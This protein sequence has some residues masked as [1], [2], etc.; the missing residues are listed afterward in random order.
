MSTRTTFRP[1]SVI[2]NGDMS[3]TS[4]TSDVTV[5]QSLTRLSY[6]AKWTGTTPIGTIA[7]QVSNDYSLNADGTVNNAGTWNTLTV[8][9]N[10]TLVTS[11]PVTGNTG[12]GFIDVEATAAYAARLVYTKTSGTGTLNV[13]INAKVS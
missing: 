11:V 2:T 1:K 3:A 10:G 4:I 6:A 9:Y 12:N 7:V 8:E 13:T 5:L